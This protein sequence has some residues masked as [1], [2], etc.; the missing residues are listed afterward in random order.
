[1]CSKNILGQT[2][3]IPFQQHWL[4]KYMYITKQ[5]F[6]LLIKQF[7]DNNKI[8]K[9]H[10]EMDLNNTAQLH[11][12]LLHNFIYGTMSNVVRQDHHMM[13]YLSVRQYPIWSPPTHSYVPC[14]YPP[15]SMRHI[16]NDEYKK[17][18]ER[19]HGIIHGYFFII[20][21]QLHAQN[22]LEWHF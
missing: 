13:H 9:F 14:C 15:Q 3:N 1:M 8:N 21:L 2:I 10:T 22:N 7:Y 18:P 4:W 6:L 5:T 12:N 11:L 16:T 20:V 17:H 19:N